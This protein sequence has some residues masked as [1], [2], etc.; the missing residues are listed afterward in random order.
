LVFEKNAN[1]FAENCRKSPKIVII[2]STPDLTAPRQQIGSFD[3]STFYLP[4][5][6]QRPR[7]G[8][9]LRQRG[10]VVVQLLRQHLVHAEL[11]RKMDFLH[12]Q[13]ALLFSERFCQIDRQKY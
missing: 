12:C 1:F 9:R 6:R 8:V 3:H 5:Q 10:K 4:R 2:T 13:A 11:K 7:V